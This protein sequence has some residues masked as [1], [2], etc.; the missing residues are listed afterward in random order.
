[1]NL[2]QLI[3]KARLGVDAILPGNQVSSLWSDE[4]MVDL[5]NEAYEEVWRQFRLAR[6]NWG[7]RTV[8]QSDADFTRMGETYRPSVELVISPEKP[9]VL[10]P[11]DCGQVAR[12]LCLSN[13]T[14]RFLPAEFVSYHWADLEQAVRDQFSNLIISLPDYLTVYYDVVDLRTLAFVPPLSQTLKIQVDYI[15]IRVPLTYSTRGTVAASGTTLTGTGTTWVDDG[16]AAGESGSL[17]DLVVLDRPFFSIGETPVSIARRYPRVA[18]I[19]SNTSAVLAQ[20]QTLSSGTPAALVMVPALPE[21]THRWLASLVSALMLRKVNP[22]LSKKASEEV[23]ERFEAGVRPTA[24]RRQDQEST[25]TEDA[26]EF[27]ITTSW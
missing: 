27:G 18:R 3:R 9:T 19:D 23:R 8:R 17:C 13:R 7:L 10:L 14:V 26:E 4:E 5:V 16:V 20:A 21:D 11:P 22:E 6:K 24:G 2:F 25:V 12:I 15:P 1:M